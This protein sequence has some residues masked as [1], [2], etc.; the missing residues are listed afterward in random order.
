MENV[1]NSKKNNGL[2]LVESIEKGL[3]YSMFESVVKQY[4]FAIQDFAEMLGISKRTLTRRKVEKKL[5]KTESDRL[6]LIG[7][8]LNKATEL[9]ENDKAKAMQW[10]NSSNRALGDRTPLQMAQTETGLREVENLIFR[11]EHG[12]FS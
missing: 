10:L 2:Q 3:S 6:V 11:L 7:R 5:S 12:V 9:F 8:M 4:S 1:L